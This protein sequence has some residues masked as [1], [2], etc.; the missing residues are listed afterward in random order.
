MDATA[1]QAF[2]GQYQ[3]APNFILTVTLDGNQLY[4]QATG[5]QR[6]G[7]FPESPTR[8]FLKVV[9]AQLDFDLG[10]DRRPTSVTLHQNGRDRLAKRIN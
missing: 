7:I 5:Q 4:A 1:K 3:L 10:P 2:V 8:F 9:D 6:S